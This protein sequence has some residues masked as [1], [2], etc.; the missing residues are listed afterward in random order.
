M[1]TGDHGL[2]TK[3]GTPIRKGR[4]SPALRTAVTLIVT[5]ALSIADAAKRTG[6]KVTSLEIALRKPHVKAFKSDVMR[7]W[8][9]SKTEKAWHT[10]VDLASGAASEDVKLKAARFLIEQD[11]AAKSAMPDQAR[12][13]VQIINH[14]TVN[15]GQLPSQ[16]LSGVIEAQ[17]YQPLALILSNS[18]PV[19]RAESDEDDGGA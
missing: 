15:T 3:D 12:Q 2:V 18:R 4:V 8:R 16:Q 11:E 6:Y 1:P 13:L 9:D 14:G 19:G 5:D 10:V 17:P 7:A